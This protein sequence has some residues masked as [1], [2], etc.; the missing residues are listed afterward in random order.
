MCVLYNRIIY[1]YII[2]I[3]YIPQEF[4]FSSQMCHVFFPVDG[5]RSS[6][7]P[8]MGEPSS[9]S[10]MKVFR[11]TSMDGWMEITLWLSNIAI[12]NDHL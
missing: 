8:P 7:K 9:T 5:P 3:P 2:Y 10:S 12:E 4:P 1:L 6:K 11:R